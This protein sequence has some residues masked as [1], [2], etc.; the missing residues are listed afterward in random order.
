MDNFVLDEFWFSSQERDV[1]EAKNIRDKQIE[2][3]F[4]MNQFIKDGFSAKNRVLFFV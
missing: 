4:C 2:E 1:S 3:L